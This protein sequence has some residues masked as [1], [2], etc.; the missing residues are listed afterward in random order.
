MKTKYFFLIAFLLF[1][2]VLFAQTKVCYTYDKAGNRT[3]RTVC[4]K[5]MEATVD[6]VSIAKTPAGA[7]F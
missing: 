2:S 3:A 1:D 6:S 7:D 4:L 5:S